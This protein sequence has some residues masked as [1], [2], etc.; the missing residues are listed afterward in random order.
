MID[1]YWTGSSYWFFLYNALAIIF[2]DFVISVGKRL[3]VKE[4]RAT[5]LLGYVWTLVWFTYSTPLYADWAMVAGLGSHRVF[6]RSLVVK[7]TLSY[8]AHMT[9]VDVLAW[10]AQKCAI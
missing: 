9:G 4:G 2:E 5:R 8:F 7:P 3:G 1:P 6:P 10:V